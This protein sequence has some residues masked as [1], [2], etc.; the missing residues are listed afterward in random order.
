MQ[1][2]IDIIVSQQ[3]ETVGEMLKSQ[4]DGSYFIP[5]LSFTDKDAKHNLLN[6]LMRELVRTFREFQW[7]QRE[8][9]DPSIRGILVLW[10]RK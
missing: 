6:K 9:L 8:S 3:V 4:P 5:D 1:T 2:E 7:E 10:R